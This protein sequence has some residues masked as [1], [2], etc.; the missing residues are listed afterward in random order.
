MFIDWSGAGALQ[1]VG[2][3]G[4]P[5][6]PD[7]IVPALAGVEGARVGVVHLPGY[8]RSASLDGPY[9]FDTVATLL[10]EALGSEPTVLVGMSGGAY[11]AL[12]LAQRGRLDLRGMVL[13]GPHPGLATE[14][15]RDGFRGFGPLLRSG[16]DVRDLARA[17]WLLDGEAER[18]EAEE[19]LA[20]MD[21][22]SRE[23]LARECEAFADAP[24]LLPSLGALD[25]PVTLIA[26]EGDAAVPIS[27]ARAVHAALPAAELHVVEGAGHALTVFHGGR[28]AGLVHRHLSRVA[29]APG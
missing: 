27:L 24:D 4:M 22:T 12:Q 3:H 13:I 17:R 9:D 7:A 14:Q 20:W 29:G 5:Q 26:G 15:E 28:V 21:A 23:V 11:R 16:A 8:G 6:P 25:L 2:I 10:E 1:V 18:S 19:V